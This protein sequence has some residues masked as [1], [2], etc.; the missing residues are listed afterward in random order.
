MR[1]TLLVLTFIALPSVGHP[2][3]LSLEE[4]LR[5]A[6]TNS[7]SLAQSRASAESASSLLSAAK[8]ERWPTLSLTATAHRIDDVPSVEVSTPFGSG[9]SFDLGTHESYLADFRLA[10]P[11]YTGGRISSGI[12]TARASH[13]HRKALQD[14]ELDLLFYETR[15]DYFSYCRTLQLRKVARASIDRVE[16][17]RNDVQSRYEAGVADSVDVLEAEL[18]YARAEFALRQARTRT[19]TA[20]IELGIQLG[21]PAHTDLANVDSLPTPAESI[22]PGQP[23]TIR[24]EMRAADA[25]VALSSARV[26]AESA[27][28][29]PTVSAYVAYSYGKPNNDP[30]HDEWKDITTVGARL[31]WA[32]NLGNSTGSRKASATHDLDA[33][34]HQRRAV[35]EQ[36]DKQA[37]LAYEQLKLAH[38]HF[39]TSRK[40]HAIAQRKYELSRSKHQEGAISSNRLVDSEAALTEAESLLAAAKADYYIAQSSYLYALG[41][42]KLGKGS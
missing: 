1:K 28:Q 9:L 35:S 2:T 30:F 6:E 13:D 39:L 5:L 19:R 14:A 18:A 21:L 36:I 26:K 40:E 38:E 23:G 15:L 34:S 25:A 37:R 4:A 31:D 22:A 3:D 41:S 11:V 29:F 10:L 33:V 17:L 12:T 20:G 24:P 8:A 27:T 32:F 16:I 7:H 42:D